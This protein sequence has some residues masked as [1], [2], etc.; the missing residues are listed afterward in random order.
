MIPV[1]GFVALCITCLQYKQQTNSNGYS[2]HHVA[3]ATSGDIDFQAVWTAVLNMRAS[4]RA[5]QPT[6]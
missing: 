1:P 4:N 3:V 5:W 2:L 6:W